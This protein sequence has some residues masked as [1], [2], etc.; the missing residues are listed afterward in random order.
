MR[1]WWF[2]LLF[3]GLA[4]AQEQP[5]VAVFELEDSKKI[6]KADDRSGLREVIATQLAGS[7]RFKV[8]PADQVK[9]ALTAKRRRSYDPCYA[10]RCQ[11]EI[12]NELAVSHTLVGSIQRF[13]SECRLTLTLY[14]LR[15][16]ASGGGAQAKGRCSA[17]D[18]AD[19]AETAAQRLVRGGEAPG[20]DHEPKVRLESAW[21]S[22]VRV[23]ATEA[24]DKSRRAKV[25]EQFLK[26]F[27]T[28]NPREG[29]A[30]ALLAALKA[31]KEPGGGRGG[32][33]VRVSDGPFFMGCNPKVDTEC[34]DDEKPGKT[35]QVAAFKIDETEVTVSAYAAC[36]KAVVCTSPSTGGACNWGRVDRGEH[37]VNCV[38][39]NQATTYCGWVEKRLPTEAE[40]E[41]AA[42]GTDG[43]KYSWGNQLDAAKA[44]LFGPMD[45]FEKTAPVGS[46]KE[47]AKNGA[48]PYGALDM[49]GN[50]WE[51]VSDGYK[52][53]AFRSIR[54]GGWN[55]DP[56]LGRASIRRRN[57]PH[58]RLNDLGFRC[59]QSE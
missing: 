9:A 14:S 42:R 17:S 35:V 43:R 11:I 54:G 29:E 50:V 57:V 48:S 32:V 49:A 41:K 13:D 19:L 45:G 4:H 27:A 5:V 8:V 23:A 24:L 44:N 55:L 7:G 52:S 39:W 31:G 34:Y 33:M 28:D 12:G 46:F 21:T 25:I 26:D 20:A 59:A 30:K 51:W 38:D 16:A 53:G 22:V 6:L 1:G 47:G 15:E 37:P 56:I 40:W 3:S 58:A 18:L 10:E 2:C 36:V